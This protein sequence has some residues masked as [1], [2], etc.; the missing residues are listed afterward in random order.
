MMQNKKAK[1]SEPESFVIFF[2]F[3]VN[4]LEYKIER[5]TLIFM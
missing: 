5:Q 1:I 3:T 4:I 2:W